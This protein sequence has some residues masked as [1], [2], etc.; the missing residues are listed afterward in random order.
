MNTN[1]TISVI[2]PVYNTE[3]YLPRCLDSII[4]SDYDA[5]EIICINDGSKDN[6]LAVLRDYQKKDDRIRIID[7]PNGGVSNARNIGLANATGDFIAF[8]DSDDWVHRQ[9]FSVLMECQRRFDADI[10]SCDY[11]KTGEFIGDENIALNDVSMTRFNSNSLQ[12]RKKMMAYIWGKV[13]RADIIKSVR[14]DTQVAVCEDLVFNI[15][16]LNQGKVH[17]LAFADSKLY[18]YY[19][20]ETSASNSCEQIERAKAGVAL[21]RRAEKAPSKELQGIYLDEAF[22]LLIKARYE[23]LK[24]PEQSQLENVDAM[25]NDWQKHEKEIQ[26]LSRKKSMLFRMFANYPIIY[27]CFRKTIRTIRK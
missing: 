6:S 1:Q 8:I 20:R 4:N 22:R 16:V 23:M 7:I 24:K 9:Y 5:L 11:L 12:M 19:N 13:Y 14:F 2:I 25:I 27:K 10:A 15:D 26:P 21:T 17:S 18:Y 3:K